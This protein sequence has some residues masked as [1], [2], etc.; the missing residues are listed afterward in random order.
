MERH[1]THEVRTAR[2]RGVRGAAI[3]TLAFVATACS[4][5]GG[6]GA[7]S[8]PAP[9]LSVAFP[10]A[11]LGIA[12]DGGESTVAIRLSTSL[13]PLADD[14]SIL[15]GDQGTGTATS[16]VD[17]VPFVAQRVTFPAGSVDGDMRS[18]T[19]EVLDDDEPEP[20]ETIRL[21]LAAPSDGVELFGAS[22]LDVQI[23]DDEPKPGA[24]ALLT[25]DQGVVFA[26]NQMVEF[27][28]TGLGG[29]S[30]ALRIAVENLGDSAFA[31]RPPV[32]SGDAGDFQ[33]ELVEINGAPLPTPLPVA[34]PTSSAASRTP[35]PFLRTSADLSAPGA[36]VPDVEALLSIASRDSLVITGVP[37]PARGRA[38]ETAVDLELE[39]LPAAITATTRVVVDGEPLAWDPS[40][41][42]TS[43]WRGTVAG[44][45]NSKVFL[46]LSPHGTRGW[47]RLSPFAPLLHLVSEPK[48]APGAAPLRLYFADDLPQGLRRFQLP[49]CARALELTPTERALVGDAAPRPAAT[50]TPSA[51][52]M[53]AWTPS[54][55]R[56]IIETDVEYFDLF[57]SVPAATTYTN[58]LISS[59]SELY[60]RHVQTTFSIAQINVYPDGDPFDPEFENDAL[61]ML[62]AVRAKYAPVLGGSWP[63]AAELVHMLSGDSLG[64]GI[65]YVDVIGNQ[66]F[67]F[68]VSG[69]LTGSINWGTFT[70]APDPL[71]WDYTVVA[72]ELGHGFGAKHTHEYCPPIDRCFEGCETETACSASSLM[73][74]CHLC[75]QGLMNIAPR[76]H[77]LTSNEMRRLLPSSVTAP[78]VGGD[79][80]LVFE[81]RFEPYAATGTR[82]ATLR[83]SHGAP[84]LPSPF[85]VRL[86]GSAQ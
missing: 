46:G 10:T 9:P 18:V 74:Y 61:A 53:G 60:E 16:G 11:S 78:S 80:E 55:V 85:R 23:I 71:I 33:V 66:N 41:N 51:M 86:G 65:A 39:A 47:I 48:S 7:S 58:Q 79:V 24:F 20:P 82:S 31:W 84:N 50:P 28:D 56:L 57:G 73:S 22:V 4:G 21:A 2:H 59:L 17:Y 42:G 15:V 34:M 5:G 26:D 44:A 12:E 76:F 25:D 43:M 37:I 19:I 8:T 68:G 32:L 63:V 72:H 64:G 6:G 49:R 54:D 1:R 77:A 75:P 83:F 3:A 35:F 27:A 30:T 67:A 36:L 40:A 70:G 29:S 62:D 13:G 45:P 81:V 69:D 38:A 52:P 14:V